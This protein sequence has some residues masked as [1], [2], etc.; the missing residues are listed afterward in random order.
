MILEWTTIVYRCF[1]HACL[2]LI[3]SAGGE[4]CCRPIKMCLLWI[5]CA[6][7]CYTVG[8]GCRFKDELSRD[9]TIHCNHHPKKKASR[10]TL[11]TTNL[12]LTVLGSNSGLRCGA[13]PYTPRNYTRIIHPKLIR[14]TERYSF[15]YGG[16]SGV[17]CWDETVQMRTAFMSQTQPTSKRCCHP[18]TA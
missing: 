15:V 16:S 4:M 1:T 9:L 7:K 12:T 6:L 11:S 3:T 8:S 10:T 14:S 18:E 5:L 13:R 17:A 2:S